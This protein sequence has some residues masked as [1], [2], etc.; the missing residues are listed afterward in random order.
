MPART[1]TRIA[2]ANGEAGLRPVSRRHIEALCLS[3]CDFNQKSRLK[4]RDSVLVK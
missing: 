2:E 4:A 1:C 3:V